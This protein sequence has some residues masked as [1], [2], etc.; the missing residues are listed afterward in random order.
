MDAS[1]LISYVPGTARFRTSVM[2]KAFDDALAKA[3]ETTDEAERVK[4]LQEAEKAIN[5]EPF[6]VYLYS[7]VDIY[8]ARSW[9]KGFTPRADQTIRLTNMGVTPK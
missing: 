8:A 7:P 2:P 4:W 1:A 5:E 9:V 6:A 3:G